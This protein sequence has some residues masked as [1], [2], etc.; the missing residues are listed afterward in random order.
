MKKLKGFLFAS[1]LCAMLALAGCSDSSSSHNPSTV[2]GIASSGAAISGTVTLKDANGEELGP[3]NIGADGSFTFIVD[4]LTPPF[5]IKA[6]AGEERWFSYAAGPGKANVN[7]L[8]ML[9]LAM[10]ME[11]GDPEDAYEDPSE[12]TDDAIASALG[13]VQALFANIFEG[14]GVDEDF[15]PFSG[16]CTVN[17][18]G[19][20]ALFDAL[21][22][23]VA[24]GNLTITKKATSSVVVD[25][26]PVAGIDPDAP[27]SDNVTTDLLWG[28][29]NYCYLFFDTPAGGNGSYAGAGYMTFVTDTTYTAV[30]E[31]PSSGTYPGV[32][33]RD[34]SGVITFDGISSEPGFMTLDR[35]IVVMPDMDDS[36]GDD[37]GISILCKRDTSLTAADI[38]GTYL[39]ME[40][41][42]MTVDGNAYA[43]SEIA[44]LAFN[45][46]GGYT[47]EGGES[48]TYSVDAGTGRITVNSPDGALTGMVAKGGDVIVV[49]EYYPADQEAAIS[50]LVRTSS[51]DGWSVSSLNG[52]Y[53]LSEL[54]S[55]LEVAPGAGATAAYTAIT[56]LTMAGGVTTGP[57]HHSYPD[58]ETVVTTYETFTSHDEA[59]LT[60]DYFVVAGE[61][62]DE[63]L[64]GIATRDGEFFVMMSDE[65]GLDD[66]GICLGVKT[67]FPED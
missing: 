38:S 20:D 56:A 27:L 2:T 21:D 43:T 66:A 47:A 53:Y 29:Y 10:A 9:A 40:L 33:A 61:A 65:E 12:V 11:S 44:V 19:I 42:R 26:T 39:V 24:E 18:D 3:E 32:Y 64:L 45:G 1:V 34:L 22:F 14:F 67:I 6:E 4:G 57:I 30:E 55:D 7:P 62:E 54:Y 8:T 25:E 52:E 31:S 37:V 16:D 15:D 36:D 35:D 49:P 28:T 60:L 46:S 59:Q 13:E 23:T 5:V 63:D 48:G 51:K 17:H 58:G 41:G 50:I